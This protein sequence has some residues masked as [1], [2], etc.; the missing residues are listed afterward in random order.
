MKLTVRSKNCKIKSNG[1]SEKIF[2]FVILL[3]KFMVGKYDN[4]PKQSSQKEGGR[5]RLLTHRIE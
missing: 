1:C 5:G 2:L 4:F 3:S